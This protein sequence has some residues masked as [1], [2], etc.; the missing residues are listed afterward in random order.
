MN[1]LNIE[2]G[3]NEVSRGLGLTDERANELQELCCES[4]IK[5]DNVVEVIDM[6]QMI[7]KNHNELAYCN[8]RIGLCL[9]CPG[10][11]IRRQMEK[12]EGIDEKLNNI[13][14]KRRKDD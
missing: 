6:M 5:Y 1:I 8:F 14:N 11:M 4:V 13:W 10:S 7:A 3:A 9:R 12:D 2:E